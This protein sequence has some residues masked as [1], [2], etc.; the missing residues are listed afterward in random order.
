MNGTL[1]RNRIIIVH[2]IIIRSTA[3][4][5]VARVVPGLGYS[6]DDGSMSEAELTFGQHLQRILR[7]HLS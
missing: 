5:Y 4:A 3:G 2:A 7:H 1:P 6:Q